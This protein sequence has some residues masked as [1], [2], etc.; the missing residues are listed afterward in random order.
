MRPLFY[1]FIISIFGSTLSLFAQE[2]RFFISHEIEKAYQEGTRS[3]DGKPGAQYWQNM[4][5]YQ[6]DV[7]VFP[8][9][10]KIEGSEEVTYYNNSPDVL[11]KIII[12]LY[13]DV[14][15]KGNPRS[16]K[17]KAE[18]INDGVNLKNLLINGE[19]YE[20]SDDKLISR[21]GTNMRVEL[22]KPLPAG[23]Q[24]ALVIE[25]SYQIPETTIKTAAYDSTSFFV[26]D[27][28]VVVSI[29][30]SKYTIAFLLLPNS[31]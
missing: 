9:E 12:R 6:I 17:V 1:L 7:S 19:S 18:D 2:K 21:K 8:N 4:V 25:W 10:K 22:K 24:L 14:Y 28:F 27:A 15:K 29:V 31:M 3:Y 26:A 13:H 16:R 23:E 20:L 11:D 30:F 5:D